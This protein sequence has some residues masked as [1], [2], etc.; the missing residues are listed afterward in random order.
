V[1]SGTFRAEFFNRVNLSKFPLPS[2]YGR[3]SVDLGLYSTAG[4]FAADTV[5]LKLIFRS[6]RK[7]RHRGHRG[8][9]ETQRNGKKELEGGR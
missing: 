5:S 9:A 7:I 2:N 1:E 4:D 6:E 3:C 8:A